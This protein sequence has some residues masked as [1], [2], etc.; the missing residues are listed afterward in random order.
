MHSFSPTSSLR[1]PSVGRFRGGP[2][3]WFVCLSGIAAALLLAACGS[4][5][6]EK[7]SSPP[8]VVSTTTTTGAEVTTPTMTIN[9]HT[10]QVPTEGGTQPIHQVTDTG[11]QIILTATGALPQ[12]LF[13]AVSTPVTWTNLTNRTVTVTVTGGGHS[14]QSIPPGGP[15]TW[16]PNVLDFGYVVS[17]GDKGGVNVGAFNQ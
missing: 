8:K 12:Q 17:N 9:G 4:S 6:A 7:S 5:P 14:P 3:R 16:T 15:Y 2:R 11:Q 1:T 10:L 13:S